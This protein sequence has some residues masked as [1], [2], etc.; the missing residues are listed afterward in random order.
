V[1]VGQ[2][3]S[4]RSDKDTGAQSD[5]Y[6]VGYAVVDYTVG[7]AKEGGGVGGGNGGTRRVDKQRPSQVRSGHSRR[8]G[9]LRASVTDS[10]SGEERYGY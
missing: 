7:K 8:D 3:A 1:G 10:I 6:C 2:T 9:I 4:G 5:G